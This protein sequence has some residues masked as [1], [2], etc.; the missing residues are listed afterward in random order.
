[1]NKPHISLFY[2]AVGSMKPT[3][4]L[5]QGLSNR[6]IYWDKTI[7]DSPDGVRP[8]SVWKDSHMR[9]IFEKGYMLGFD[10][11]KMLKDA[12]LVQ[13]QNLERAALDKVD[14]IGK[15]TSGES[16]SGERYRK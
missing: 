7:N 9:I 8:F 2:K 1:M 11:A 10:R 5:Y 6:L 15:L 4:T 3:A 14:F 13:T 16:Y 12:E